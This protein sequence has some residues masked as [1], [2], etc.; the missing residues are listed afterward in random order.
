[1]SKS[2]W[3][4]LLI[5]LAILGASTILVLFKNPVARAWLADTSLPY[6]HGI[7]RQRGLML[8]MRDGTRLYTNVLLPAEYSGTL[9]TVLM[10]TTYGGVSFAWSKFFVHHGYAVVQQYVRGRFG[11]EGD[12]SP[13]QYS[14]PDGYDTLS[15]IAKQPWSNGKIGS[16]GCSFLGETQIIMAA[17]NHPNHI[18]MIVDGAGGAIGTAK[19]SYG[20]FG[21]Y[22][23]GVLNLASALGWFT[24]FGASEM[25]RTPRETDYHAKLQQYTSSLPLIDVAKKVVP[26]STGFE[27]IVGHA[28]TDPW[29]EEQGYI[30]RNDRFS[31]ATLHVNTWYDQT[32]YDSFKLAQ[33]MAENAAHPRAE[34]QHLLIGP[35]VHCSS[36]ELS[37]GVQK[38]GNMAIDYQDIDYPSIY[39]HWFDHW[40]KD[41]Q[42]DLPPP[43]QYYLIHGSQW[44]STDTWPPMNTA[45]QLYLSKEFSLLGKPEEPE[46]EHY[47]EYHYDPNKPVPTLGGTI[48][49]TGRPEDIQGAVDQRQL[50]ERADV[51]AYVSPPL[52]EDLNLVGNA[53][54]SLFV[55]SSAVD[56]DF[57]LK[58]V[59]IYPDGST[60]NIQDGVVRMRYR[61]GISKEQLAVP[62][63]IYR[64][65]LILRP[66][67]YRFK[68]GHRVGVHISSSNFP[69]LARNLNTGEDNHRSTNT[70]IAINRVYSGHPYASYIQ[71]P[72]ARIPINSLATTTI[73]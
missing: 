25:N 57:T 17:E 5:C 64:L 44:L 22:E 39:L 4:G 52:S 9:P 27:D 71:L 67:A 34:Q 63:E 51:L 21:V 30:D 2:I 14:G 10:R 59:D 65:E 23:N 20:F 33:H 46:K 72:T 7:K 32:T 31:T 6:R 49:C 12:Y 42:V 19:D 13:H 41:R 1:M 55:S 69:R 29:W 40:L 38:I 54:A 70:K 62:G 35:G 61:G 3:L 8:P 60:Y 56:T 37:S 16:F 18:A 58:L 47:H 68:A 11:S 36:A 53:S 15:W 26:F 28:L 50:V 45:K 73:H 24:G 43:I 48:C 66:S